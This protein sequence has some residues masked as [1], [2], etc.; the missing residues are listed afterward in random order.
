M[1]GRGLLLNLAVAALV[2][3]GFWNFGQGAYLHLKAW[4]A[5]QLLEQA[6][7]RTLAGDPAARPWP[8][9][10]TQPVARLKVPGRKVD[11]IVLAGATGR[12]LAFGPGYSLASQ[13]PGQGVTVFSGH[14]DTH[15]GFLQHLRRGERITVQLPDGSE[16]SYR[17]ERASVTDVRTS[18]LL[19]PPAAQGLVLVTCYPFNV[20]APTG[21]LRYVV[22]A[23]PD[24]T[25]ALAERG[26]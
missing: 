13:L 8:W 26:P 18:S 2:T 24:P 9:A 21:P 12:T 16:H 20:V 15:F 25:S 5:Q 6:W 10:D 1:K 17:V 3:V 22:T 19:L 23:T 14:R 11:Q 7:E 4:L